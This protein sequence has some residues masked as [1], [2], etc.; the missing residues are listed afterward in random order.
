MARKLLGDSS[1][2]E[3]PVDA[4]LA[5]ARAAND[6]HTMK[7]VDLSNVQRMNLSALLTVRDDLKH[8]VVSACCKYGLR[9]EQGRFI[10][11]LSVDQILAVVGN[12]GE[13]CLFPPRRDLIDLLNTP[14]PLAGPLASVHPPS[15]V[16]SAG[17]TT[18]STMREPATERV[19]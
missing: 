16:A 18:A 11:A 19:R 4:A 17:P 7:T 5:E 10:E 6:T 8:D 9:P 12:M 14:I 3:A 13:E 1:A 15:Q 2:G